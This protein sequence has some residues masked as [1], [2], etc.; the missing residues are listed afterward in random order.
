MMK[1]I[2][3]REWQRIIFLIGRDGVAKTIEFCNET[4]K[5]YRKALKAAEDGVNAYGKVYKTELVG[6][7]VVLESFILDVLYGRTEMSRRN[8]AKADIK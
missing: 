1:D 5:A 4:I 3:E 2:E 8:T 6:S 7:I